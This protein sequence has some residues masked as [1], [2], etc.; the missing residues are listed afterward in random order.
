MAAVTECPG[1]KG[2][3]RLGVVGLFATPQ[4]SAPRCCLK[5][6][7]NRQPHSEERT[8]LP[9]AVAASE[10]DC[11]ARRPPPK[12]AMRPNSL[13]PRLVVCVHSGHTGRL[14]EGRFLPKLAKEGKT[15]GDKNNSL[16]SQS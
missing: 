11:G 13:S 1:W 12:L 9:S 7:R 4:C 14:F 15:L 10:V 16:V 2:W 5:A 6:P 8:W 3:W